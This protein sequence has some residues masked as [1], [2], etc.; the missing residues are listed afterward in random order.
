MDVKP[1]WCPDA[2]RRCRRSY[3]RVRPDE[4]PVWWGYCTNSQLSRRAVAPYSRTAWA[5]MRC[6]DPEAMRGG[7]ARPHVARWQ[8][9]AD[10]LLGYALLP[11]IRY[12]SL[13]LAQESRRATVRL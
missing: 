10:L 11:S 13:T 12:L 6:I 1:G 8:T 4:S 2:A 3:R 9:S 5:A 7:G